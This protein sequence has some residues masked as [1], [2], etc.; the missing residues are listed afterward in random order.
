MDYDKLSYLLAQSK[1][2]EAYGETD[3]VHAV[4]RRV[5]ELLSASLDDGNETVSDFIPDLPTPSASTQSSDGLET[6]MRKQL[7]EIWNELRGRP[8]HIQS[9]HNKGVLIEEI[10]RLRGSKGA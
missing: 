4:W 1:Q 6:M 7:L 10:R 9:I 5:I 3:L 8:K 2:L